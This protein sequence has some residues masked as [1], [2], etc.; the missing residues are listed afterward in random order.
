MN[1]PYCNEDAELVKGSAVYPHR[2]DLS[3]LNFWM[4][5]PCNAYTGCHKKH[6]KWSPEGTTPKGTLADSEL[7]SLRSQVHRFFDPLWREGTLSRNQAYGILASYL[8]IGKSECHIGFFDEQT[9]RDALKLGTEKRK[10]K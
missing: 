4:C 2:P 3:D 6:P 9:C 5:K 10:L 1:C 8:N 7:R